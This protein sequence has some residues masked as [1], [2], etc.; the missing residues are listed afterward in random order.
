M[1]IES[2]EEE[3]HHNGKEKIIV[4]QNSFITNESFNLHMLRLCGTRKKT[5]WDHTCVISRKMSEK[6]EKHEK[7][8][9]KKLDDGAAII[10]E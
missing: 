5:E 4:S 2:K 8:S 1:R 9:G 7:N 6:N 10:N 3:K